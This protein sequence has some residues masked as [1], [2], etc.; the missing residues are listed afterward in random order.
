MSTSST[1]GT[2]R[3]LSLLKLLPGAG[4]EFGP[5]ASDLLAHV[6]SHDR[7]DA[8]A[9]VSAPRETFRGVTV[10]DAMNDEYV[11]PLGR[12]GQSIVLTGYRIAAGFIAERVADEWLELAHRERLAK[13]LPAARKRNAPHAHPPS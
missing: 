10:E 7:F 9:N 6:L 1:T 13:G 4:S 8:A 11:F 3:T 2:T 5:A 12:T